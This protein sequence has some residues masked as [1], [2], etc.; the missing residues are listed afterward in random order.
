MPPISGIDPAEALV[1]HVIHRA[2]KTGAKTDYNLEF[3]GG[4]RNLQEKGTLCE[5]LPRIVL[6]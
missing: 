3:Q 1:L 5:V 4:I 2:F 6:K